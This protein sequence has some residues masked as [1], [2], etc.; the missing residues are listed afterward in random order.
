[1]RGGFRFWALLAGGLV[2]VGLG[3]LILAYIFSRAV[4]A[5]GIFGAFLVVAFLLLVF[6]WLYD[7]R[8]A[9]LSD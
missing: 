5:W 6:A 4:V 2:A 9:K 8:Q 1:V 7:R 3:L